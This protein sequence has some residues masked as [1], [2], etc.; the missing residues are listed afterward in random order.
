M[1]TVSYHWGCA[2]IGLVSGY[3]KCGERYEESLAFSQN[4]YPS[5][6]YYESCTCCGDLCNN[7]TMDDDCSLPPVFT[8]E[9]YGQSAVSYN[10]NIDMAKAVAIKCT[11]TQHCYVRITSLTKI[12]KH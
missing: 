7:S 2:N 6:V 11:A 1:T 4:G 5:V 8:E 10:P 12:I 9:C 3:P